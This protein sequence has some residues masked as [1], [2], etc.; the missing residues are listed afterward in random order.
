MAGYY[1][2]PAYRVGSGINFEPVTNALTD[3]TNTRFKREQMDQQAKNALMDQQRFQAQEARQ[4]ELMNLQRE[5][6]ALKKAE[7]P[8][9]RQYQQGQLANQSA[10]IKALEAE[11]AAKL[12]AQQREEAF[13]A[14]FDAPPAAAAPQTPPSR[15]GGPRPTDMGEGAG[16]FSMLGQQPMR[17]QAP[18]MYAG[19][20]KPIDIAEG[21][22]GPGMQVGDRMAPPQQP[23]QAQQPVTLRTM[24]DKLDPQAKAVAMGLLQSGKREEFLQMLQSGGTPPGAKPPTEQQSKD[25]FFVRRMMDEERTLAQVIPMDEKGNIKGA[26]NFDPTKSSAWAPDGDM[27]VAWGLGKLPTRQYN[28]PEWNRYYDAA[29]SWLATILRKDTGA[30]VTK[31]EMGWYFPMLFPQPGDTPELVLDKARRR[32]DYMQ[33]LKESA[34]PLSDKMNKDYVPPQGY[35]GQADRLK[36]KYGLE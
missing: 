27:D 12:R 22:T 24:F 28:S 14:Q 13:M 6:F 9:N 30:T 15:L 33:G 16:R 11:T 32:N 18:P 21:E 23:Q 5:E 4:N 34:G 8:F 2:L 17:Q 26:N 7:V 20:P 31:E 25:A 1:P 19:G 10:Q 29:R 36:Q 3:L 35:P